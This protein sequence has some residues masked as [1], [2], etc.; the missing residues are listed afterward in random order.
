M[1]TM[2]TRQSAGLSQW[3][4]NFIAAPCFVPVF[5]SVP[6]FVADF[7]PVPVAD[8]VPV[9]F[10]MRLFHSSFAFALLSG[11]KEVKGVKGVKDK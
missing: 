10:F 6:V 5:V 2:A 11:V 1:T 7:V 4:F 3:N 9:F 8:F